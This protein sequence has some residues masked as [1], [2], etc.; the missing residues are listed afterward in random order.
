MEKPLYRRGIVSQS[1]HKLFSCG[2]FLSKLSSK[3]QQI[4]FVAGCLLRT[5]GASA[6]SKFALEIWKQLPTGNFLTS[7]A[8]S[9]KSCEKVSYIEFASD[10]LYLLSNIWNCS[11]LTN[12]LIPNWSLKNPQIWLSENH[13]RKSL[14]T[15][16]SKIMIENSPIST[17]WNWNSLTK[18]F[19]NRFCDIRKDQS[20]LGS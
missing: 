10:D 2:T 20:V 7:H 1:V 17:F 18:K 5:S 14:T 3:F 6:Y 15:S 12:L 4:M 19:L 11:Y 8:S 9:E 13:R 16:S